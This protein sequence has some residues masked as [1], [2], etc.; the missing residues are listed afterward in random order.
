VTASG[1][2]WAGATPNPAPENRTDTAPAVRRPWLSGCTGAVPLESPPMTGTG[3]GTGARAGR[4][5]QLPVPEPAGPR[6]SGTNLHGARPG[7]VAW[8]ESCDRSMALEIRAT[9]RPEII[10]ARTSRSGSRHRR[11][12]RPRVT[13]VKQ[14]IRCGSLKA[15]PSDTGRRQ[16]RW[17][18]RCRRTNG[19]SLRA[20]VH[21]NSQHLY[22]VFRAHFSEHPL[23]N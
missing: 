5:A 6:P 23:L 15:D 18:R 19:T 13:I 12:H 3:P 1:R 7:C 11:V 10:G 17:V 22:T 14:R 20:G 8:A 21:W 9:E 2:K 4:T 16:P